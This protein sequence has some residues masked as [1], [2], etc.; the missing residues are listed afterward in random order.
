MMADIDSVLVEGVMRRVAMLTLVIC[1][2]N[3]HTVLAQT[4]PAPKATPAPDGAASRLKVLETQVWRL[5]FKLWQLESN[6]KNVTLDPTE[7]WGFRRIQTN[8]GSF[9]LSLKNVEPYLDGVRVTLHI[10]NPSAAD[11]KGFTLEA[12][13]G[14]RAPKDTEAWLKWY[15]RLTKKEF[16][17]T[18]TLSAGAWNE[19]SFVLSPV[20][21]T[22][23]GHLQVSMTTNIVSLR[24]PTRR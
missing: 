14:P 20:P 18:D 5:E 19:I 10:G 4:P 23:F 13:W 22:Q 7:L 11:Y 15:D 6:E 24:Q 12:Q 1:L 21:A 9:L 2:Q 3:T 16:S 17:F 8:N